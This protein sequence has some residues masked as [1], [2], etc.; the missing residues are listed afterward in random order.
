M[1]RRL[2]G[3][4]V[5]T[6][7]VRAV[8]LESGEP[9]ELRV[10]GQV[11][12]PPDAMRDGEVQDPAAVA[13]AIERLWRELDLP[14][15]ASV[16]V[17]IASPR[18]IVRPVDLAAM[19]EDELAGALRY[20]AQELIPIPI[21]DAYLDFLVQETLTTPEGQSVNRLLLAA[22]HRTIVDRLRAAVESAGLVV[23]GVDLVPLALARSAR[24][25]R[26]G[27]VEAQVS[28]GAGV[29]VIVVHDDGTPAFVR[30]L[31]TAGRNLTEAVATGLEVPIETAEALKRRV[32]EAPGELVAQAQAV[33]QKPVD[34]LVEDIRGSLDYYVNQPNAAAI[35][36]IVLSG[37]G[38]LLDGLAERLE[39]ATH[40][41]VVPSDLRA[42][43][44]VGD[45]GFAPED[46]PR[47][48]PFLS[49]PVG[50][51]LGVQ[52]SGGRQIDLLGG[53]R[54]LGGDAEE[55]DKKKLYRFAG[56]LAALL[57]VVLGFLTWQTMSDQDDA[58]SA[59]TEAQSQ[60]DS[61]KQQIDSL[62]EV[63]NAQS[64]IDQGKATVDAELSGAVSWSDILMNV[65]MAMPQ[66]TWL[67]T[68]T[69]TVTQDGGTGGS[70][71]SS[72]TA[73]TTTP[74]STNGGGSTATAPTAAAIAGPVTFEAKGL[75]FQSVSD[76]ISGLQQIPSMTNLWVNNAARPAAG[77]GTAT[78][79]AD[80]SVTFTATAALTPA[81]QDTAR[82]EKFRE[83]TR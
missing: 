83:Q 22:A 48:D 7:A 79:L 19:P 73:T 80:S 34:N 15:K 78:S 68:F 5:G 26:R 61:T 12:L 69:G 23:Q 72:G 46:L 28:V 76:W 3:L 8:D 47:I 60:I 67:T 50:L 10:F 36:R 33:L 24:V 31:G 25:A 35:D 56:I 42:A 16:R 45:L 70:P 20:Q 62:Q 81:A 14:K 66:D 53:A 1:A 39:A 18:V 38:A 59:K 54:R 44:Q 17:G 55:D 57:V 63:S 11:A 2:I 43:L 41:P 4:D 75:T 77:G 21:E 27:G 65:S 6:S 82:L 64:S 9:P 13:S 74:A 49:V 52:P 71:S 58:D 51:A 37:G 32:P 29:T 40:V 30:M